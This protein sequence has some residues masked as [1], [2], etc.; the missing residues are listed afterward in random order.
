MQEP[1][2]RERAA[3][4]VGSTLSERAYALIAAILFGASTPLAKRLVGTVEPRPPADGR[5]HV[6]HLLRS[7]VRRVIGETMRGPAALVPTVNVRRRLRYCPPRTGHT[8]L[9]K[10]L[11]WWKM[12]P[13][14]RYA[15]PAS[16]E[17]FAAGE[18]D[19]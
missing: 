6:T 17:R 16:V 12:L 10:V 8:K 4:S 9:P 13:S 1:S 18:D 14:K 7:D 3:F 15:Y 2:R 11:P 19:Q 5:P